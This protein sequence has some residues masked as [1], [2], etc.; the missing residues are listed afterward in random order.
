[1]PVV[2]PMGMGAL[3]FPFVFS[4]SSSFPLFAIAAFHR[5]PQLQSILPS[6]LPSIN[7]SILPSILGRGCDGDVGC[8]WRALRC[9]PSALCRLTLHSR[10]GG[11]HSP[12]PPT[13]GPTRRAGNLSVLCWWRWV[14]W[15]AAVLVLAMAAAVSICVLELFIFRCCPSLQSTAVCNFDQF[16]R[17]FFRQY[18]RGRARL[19]ARRVPCAEP[20]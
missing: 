5:C 3:L 4:S 7:P 19:M 2:L 13:H 6:I 12:N 1:M 11:A 17:K 9:A 20:G 14:L 18:M 10:T 16:F 8:G 15:A